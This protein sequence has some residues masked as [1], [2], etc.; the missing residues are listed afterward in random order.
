LSEEAR[1]AHPRTEGGPCD[2][3]RHDQD[4]EGQETRDLP[5]DLGRW[6]EHEP[7]KTSVLG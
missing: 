2:G 7:P 1:T 3:N 4:R 6:Q 5:R